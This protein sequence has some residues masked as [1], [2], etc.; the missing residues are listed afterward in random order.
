MLKLYGHSG[1]GT[2]K[3]AVRWLKEHQIP[4][5]EHPIRQT[6][7][8]RAELERMLSHMEGN[9][10]KLFNTSGQAYRAQGIKD[11][12]PDLSPAEALDL[13]AA[14]GNLIK[15]PF[16]LTEDDGFVGFQEDHWR[17]RLLGTTLGS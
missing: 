4:F 11:R 3:K 6:P 1:C 12:L 17:R 9:V 14:D 8:S 16:V 5:E 2:C 13:L 15:R 7:P 10:R